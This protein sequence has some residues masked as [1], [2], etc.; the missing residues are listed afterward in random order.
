MAL[1]A[2]LAWLVTKDGTSKRWE[3]FLLV[4]AYLGAVVA[5]ALS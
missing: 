4:G 3:G 5:Y 1:A 2:A